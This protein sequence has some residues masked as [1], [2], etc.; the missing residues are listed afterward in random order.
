MNDQHWGPT[1]SGDIV[2]IG[3]GSAG[4][5]LLERDPHLN[6]TLIEPNDHHSYPMAW[7]LLPWFHCNGLL[8]GR[9]WQTRLTKVD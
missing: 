1:I 7:T 2:V 4:I 5:G 6:I 8:K 9:E 3:G